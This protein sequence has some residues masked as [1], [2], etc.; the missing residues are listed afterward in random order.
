MASN[1]LFSADEPQQL[2]HGNNGGAASQPSPSSSTSAPSGASLFSNDEISKLEG[3][4]P[5]AAPATPTVTGSTNPKLAVAMAQKD[6]SPAAGAV[7]VAGGVQ[8]AAEPVLDSAAA[9]RIATALKPI[10][11]KYGIKALEG[12]G[13]KVGWDLY[14]ELHGAL[15]GK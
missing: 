14:H 8:M 1:V 2:N 10:A 11:Q 15:F 5:D 7:G 3:A 4:A 13:L 6:A 12:A 9:A